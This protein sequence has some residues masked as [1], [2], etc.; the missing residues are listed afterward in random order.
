MDDLKIQVV[1]DQVK[2]NKFQS[3]TP[4]TI[5]LVKSVKAVNQLLISH[6][7]L[8]GNFFCHQHWLNITWAIRNII[9]LNPIHIS[10]NLYDV[11]Y[12]RFNCFQFKGNYYS[13]LI[14]YG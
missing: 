8:I 10:L 7:L 13:L 9:L 1:F 12:V 5:V 14:S 6:R 2:F 4:S 11:I 3:V